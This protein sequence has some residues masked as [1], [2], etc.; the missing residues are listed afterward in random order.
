MK[1]V[2]RKT[3]VSTTWSSS[4]PSE[5]SDDGI[6]VSGNLPFRI[7]LLFFLLSIDQEFHQFEGWMVFHVTRE[8]PH[9]CEYKLDVIFARFLLTEAPD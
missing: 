9:Q 5:E 1:V 2:L 4:E 8:K 3:F 6:Y 7:A